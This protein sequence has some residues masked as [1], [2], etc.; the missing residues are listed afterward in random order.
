MKSFQLKILFV[1]MMAYHVIK[2]VMKIWFMS[3][4]ICLDSPLVLVQF[5]IC[6]TRFICS[7]L[8]AAISTWKGIKASEDERGLKDS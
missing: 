2:Q 5:K 3:R 1:K 8:Q 6:G 4:W 7:L